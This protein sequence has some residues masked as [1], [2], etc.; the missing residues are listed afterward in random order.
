VGNVEFAQIKAVTFDVGGTLIEPWP[1]V[2]HVYSAVAAELGYSGLSAEKLNEAF[3][4][5]WKLKQNFDYSLRAWFALVEEVFVPQLSP[6]LSQKLF[7]SL[8]QRFTDR[9]VWR[10]YDDVRPTL[11]RL[12]QRGYRLAVISNWDERLKPL[13]IDLQLSDYFETIVV[14]VDVGATKPSPKIFDHTLA[15]LNL[16]ATAVLHVGDSVDEDIV[17]PQQCGISAL[18]LDR[19]G[20]STNS[21]SSLKDLLSRSPRP[22]RSG[23]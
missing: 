4:R 12:R 20:K 13:L 21:L 16:P 11:K 6:P 1:S 3:V 23:V 2:G 17:G 19:T 7:E 15:V 8:Y 5:A 22:E 14:S 9:A 10:V 18:L